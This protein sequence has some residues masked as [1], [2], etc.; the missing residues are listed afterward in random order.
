V[1]VRYSVFWDVGIMDPIRCPETSV[2]EERRLWW[3]R[4]SKHR[5]LSIINEAI[6]VSIETLFQDEC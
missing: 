4:L 2:A 6:F 1:Q 3:E 5:L